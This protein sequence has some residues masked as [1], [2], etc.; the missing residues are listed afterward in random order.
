MPGI[1]GIITFKAPLAPLV[2]TVSKMADLLMH[3]DYYVVG[4]KVDSN[5]GIG[6]IDL[7][8]GDF[9]SR[10]IEEDSYIL[11][12]TGQIYDQ[13]VLT[14][15]ISD[16]VKQPIDL[17]NLL[18]KIFKRYGPEGL[19]G[20]NG[21]YVVI[22]W[23]KES[24]KL[25]IVNDRYG[26][27]KL[28]YW[29][30]HDKFVFASE[31]K[32]ISWFPD[33]SKKIDEFAFANLMSFGY[34]LDD[35]TLFE[36]IK[37]LPPASIAVVQDAAFSIKK[38]WDYSFYEEGEARLSEDEYIDG[39]AE[40]LT[41]AVKKRVQG[42]DRLAIPLSGGLDSRTMA[43]VLHKLN[44]VDY[45]KAYSHGH[46]HCY[47]VRFGKQIAKKLGFAHETIE[48]KPDFIEK[49]SKSFQYLSEGMAACDWAWRIDDQ[50]RIISKDNINAVLTG[51]L[52]DVLCRLYMSE[53]GLSG[54]NNE[55]AVRTIYKT[56]TD[57]FND[58]EIAYYL[59]QNLYAK[60][61]GQN[62]EVIRET[63]YNAT[64][65]SIL[66]RARYVN[67]HQRQRRFT[68]TL[69]D[70]YEFFANTVS[71]FIENE[72]VDFIL[73]VPA[74]LQVKQSLY[75]KMLIRHFPKVVKIGHSD[76]GIPI[77]PSWWQ[78]GL[79][80]RL[81]KYGQLLKKLPF[82]S[83]FKHNYGDYRHTE[84]AL[85]TDSRQFV[86]ETFQNSAAKRAFFIVERVDD[87]VQK[88]LRSNSNDYE[89]VCY[90][91]TFLV[92]ADVFEADV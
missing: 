26:F 43:A 89:K 69:L 5:I 91:L 77:K 67:L 38:Y 2:A 54:A 1:V 6:S 8:K 46:R 34:V 61:K 23:D 81:H 9:V 20:L 64:T 21:L 39:F 42:V 35:R 58:E 78:E 36:N 85:R 32:A 30:S 86:I 65:D 74:E 70:H 80:W 28:Y 15:R 29:S 47:D 14:E 45:V 24:R 57:S 55:D 87:L 51:F 79:Q 53:K 13:E 60:I 17:P 88:F 25:H 75:K 44:M 90:P 40:K 83:Y 11:G 12:F 73:H 76:S 41:N 27:R 68:S 31:Y 16:D 18:L 63:Y 66:N 56:H 49:Y 71:P 22:I 48:I 3:E 52:G 7:G 10:V 4:K 72:F 37:L 62:F 82:I 84:T 33:F 92:W 50:K 59:N 19:S